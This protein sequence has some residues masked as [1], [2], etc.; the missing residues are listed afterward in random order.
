ML[1]NAQQR[2]RDIET[3]ACRVGESFGRKEAYLPG[4]GGTLISKGVLPGRGLSIAL[5]LG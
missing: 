5:R 3:G 2:N 4:T 1:A